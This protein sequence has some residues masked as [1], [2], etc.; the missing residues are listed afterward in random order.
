MLLIGICTHV[1]S[2][3]H[4]CTEDKLEFGCEVFGIQ[5]WPLVANSKTGFAHLN[6][7]IVNHMWWAS[8]WIT[9]E[10]KGWYD[11]LAKLFNDHQ[12]SWFFSLLQASCW[13]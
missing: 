10:A 2:L 5:G 1:A 11:V 3:N 6:C 12:L 13:S 7:N 8:S 9:S 4:K